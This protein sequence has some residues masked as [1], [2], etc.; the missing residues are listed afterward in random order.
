[1]VC[2]FSS[3][4]TDSM[5][6]AGD[7][8]SLS[9][10]LSPGCSLSLK[11]KQTNKQNFKK[12]SLPKPDTLFTL[13]KSVTPKVCSLDSDKPIPRV[14]TLAVPSGRKGSGPRFV[15]N[16]LFPILQVQLKCLHL[17]RPSAWTVHPNKSLLWIELY[18]PK[19]YAK[20][21]TA[22]PIPQNV[23]SF[24]NKIVAV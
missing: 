14:L 9:L 2:G 4:S 7:S 21:L 5:E 19:R 20:F 1:M 16:L 3:A 18:P 13:L 15:H 24:R 22:P 23:T 8:L 12:S 10:C 17:A 11:N 6:P